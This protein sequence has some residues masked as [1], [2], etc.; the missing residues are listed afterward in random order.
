MKISILMKSA[1]LGVTWSVFVCNTFAGPTY[2]GSLNEKSA[3][4][5]YVGGIAVGVVVNPTFR[6]VLQAAQLGPG[7][8]GLA[9]EECMPSISTIAV[10]TLLQAGFGDEWGDFGITAYG[11]GA[12]ATPIVCGTIASDDATRVAARSMGM[13]C[14]SHTPEGLFNIAASLFGI[15]QSNTIACL[16]QVEA[17][18]GGAIG[19]VASD[20]VE[21]GFAYIKL[22]TLVP[23]R[24]RFKNGLYPMF[25]DIH[26]STT[27]IAPTP[28]IFGFGGPVLLADNP[29]M[30]QVAKI[31]NLIDE[32]TV[33]VHR[34]GGGNL[35]IF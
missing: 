29:P 23:D 2:T 25:G 9:T 12:M 34:M 14:A 32:C 24:D 10:G 27:G 16:A 7:C 1:L 5:P 4:G 6:D 18:G 31:P 13:G 19:F 28:Q 20:T 17:A 8:V 21:A 15:A 22:D 26:G 35:S 11:T 33:G 3:G 30:H